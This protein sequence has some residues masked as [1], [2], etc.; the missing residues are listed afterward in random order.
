MPFYDKKYV[1][2]FNGEL[3]GVKIKEEGRIG[4]EKI[5]NF[6]KRFD[7]GDMEAA[8]R[9]AVPLIRKRTRE[10]KALNFIIA[11]KKNVFL[12]TYFTEREEYFTMHFKDDGKLLQ[13]CSDPYPGEVW[14]KIENGT[15]RKW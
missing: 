7:K 14:E 4:A 6:I 11:D 9:K 3:R 5:F 10:I 2:I 15:I 12:N 13:I 1:F 8:V